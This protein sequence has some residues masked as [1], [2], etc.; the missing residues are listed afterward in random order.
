MPP[1]LSLAQLKAWTRDACY[2]RLTALTCPQT[3]HAQ[4]NAAHKGAT[5]VREFL[6]RCRCV[7]GAAAADDRLNAYS[8]HALS[9]RSAPKMQATN[10][11]CN[12][13]VRLR[14]DEHP[15]GTGAAQSRSTPCSPQPARGQRAP[16]LALEQREAPR[17]DAVV[18]WWLSSLLAARP[19][20]STAPA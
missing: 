18:Q 9:A 5:A 10:P 6:S 7:C 2:H 20:S 4:F 8:A 17:A 19:T 12:I 15:P 3:L 16:L 13:S 11:A 14:V 1:K